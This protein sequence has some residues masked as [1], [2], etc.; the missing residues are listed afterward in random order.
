MC[1]ELLECT[2]SLCY[3][4]TNYE[5]K[6]LLQWLQSLLSSTRRSIGCVCIAGFIIRHSKSPHAL[7]FIHSMS[8]PVGQFLLFGQ[9][10]KL[11]MLCDVQTHGHSWKTADSWFNSPVL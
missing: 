11:V 8:L 5:A 6:K 9:F 1:L 4:T 2:R 7:I 3:W 10:I